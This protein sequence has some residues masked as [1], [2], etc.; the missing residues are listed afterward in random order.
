MSITLNFGKGAIE[1]GLMGE[2][3]EEDFQLFL[4]FGRPGIWG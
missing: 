1:I 4:L 3:A 2:D